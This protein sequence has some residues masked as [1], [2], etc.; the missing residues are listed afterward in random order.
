MHARCSCTSWS[1][2]H[3]PAWLTLNLLSIGTTFSLML[4]CRESLF[5]HGAQNRSV[6]C[7]HVKLSVHQVWKPCFCLPSPHFISFRLLESIVDVVFFGVI[8]SFQESWPAC[9]LRHHYVFDTFSLCLGCRLWKLTLLRCT[10][11]LIIVSIGCFVYW[12]SS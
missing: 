11:S 8:G 3:T 9:R 1:H 7:T 4:Y 2:I 6:F 10:S 12:P 5:N